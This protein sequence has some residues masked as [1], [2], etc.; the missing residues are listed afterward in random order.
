[1]C[2][3]SKKPPNIY[4]W[5]T[6]TRN[7]PKVIC[8]NEKNAK[9]RSRSQKGTDS[10]SLATSSLG[11]PSSFQD[12]VAP[13]DELIGSF[14]RNSSPLLSELRRNE[15]NAEVQDRGDHFVLTAEL[16]GFDKKDVEVYASSNV[17]ELK[18][19]KR[20]DEK[21]ADSR[22]SRYSY[23][24]RYLTLPEPVVSGKADGTMKNGILSL[25]LLK[26]ERKRKGVARRVHLN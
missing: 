2:L 14:F 20:S 23:F 16:P 7:I 17:V 6:T 26:V 24:H 18:A 19:E 13:F 8:M 12:F 10:T 5:Y 25:K 22:Y 3:A 9:E 21:K 4:I 15:P 1:M 11:I